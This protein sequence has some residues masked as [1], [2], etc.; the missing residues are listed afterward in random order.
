MTA[1]MFKQEN[2]DFKIVV[3]PQE[4]D[5]YCESVGKEYVLELPFA[6]LGVGSFPARNFCWED[7]IKNGFDRHWVFDDNISKIRRINKGRKISCNAKK[8]IETLEEFTDRYSN[9]GITAFNYTNFVVAGSSDKKP[10]Y[11]NTH[12]YSAMLMKNDMDCRWRMKYNEDVDLCLQV[13]NKRLCTLN[14]NAFTVDKTSTTAKMKGGNQTELYKGNAYEMKVLKARSLEKIWPKYCSTIIRFKRPHH[15]V[16]WAKFKHG[17]IHR[18]NIDFNKLKTNKFKL[19][20]I[21]KIKSKS[22]KKFFK[23]TK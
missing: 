10:F 2:L 12:C 20:Q 23:E 14:F 21:D 8:A 6:N 16:N 4:Y 3:E 18:K 5:L 17:L 22:L 9:V 13:L 11:I 1:N 7:S 19:K 15:W